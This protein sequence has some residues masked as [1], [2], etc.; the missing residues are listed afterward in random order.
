VVLYDQAQTIPYRSYLK[1]RAIPQDDITAWTAIRCTPCPRTGRDLAGMNVAG[2]SVTSKL[3]PHPGRLELPP[4]DHRYRN[5]QVARLA[6]SRCCAGQ[7]P[8]LSR[9]LGIDPC[10]HTR[11]G[12]PTQSLRAPAAKD[13]VRNHVHVA[14]SPATQTSSVTIAGI[15]S[16]Q[17][18]M[19]T[20]SA[21]L[22]N[23]SNHLARCV[24]ATRTTLTH[25]GHTFGTPRRQAKGILRGGVRPCRWLP[26]FNVAR[27]VPARTPSAGDRRVD[28]ER[29]LRYRAG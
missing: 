28:G 1:G 22:R 9:L 13:P 3:G 26:N 19:G 21:H 24:L 17:W 4:P 10:T 14:P 12:R 2:P 23:A 11:R 15:Q 27:S 7:I 8:G 20:P 18:C 29:T 25:V 16:I 5:H 6:K